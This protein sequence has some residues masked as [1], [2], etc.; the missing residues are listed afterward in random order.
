MKLDMVTLKY[1]CCFFFFF[2][3]NGFVILLPLKNNRKNFNFHQIIMLLKYTRYNNLV[4]F[5]YLFILTF[6]IFKFV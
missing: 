6:G 2:T 5:C 1:L 4:L 3:K